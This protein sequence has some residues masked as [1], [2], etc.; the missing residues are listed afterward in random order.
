MQPTGSTEGNREGEDSPWQGPQPRAPSSPRPGT[1]DTVSVTTLTAAAAF[2]DLMGNSGSKVSLQSDPVRK[3]QTPHTCRPE[4]LQRVHL[5][6]GRAPPPAPSDV[7][8]HCPAHPAVL[9][10]PCVGDRS[11]PAP[12]RLHQVL[13]DTLPRSGLCSDVA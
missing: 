1:T 5:S 7:T 10:P 11:P 12:G 4:T 8:A 6:P 13:R 2:L 9:P 3:E